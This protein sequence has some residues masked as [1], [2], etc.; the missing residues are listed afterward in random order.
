M[1][2][3]LNR[4]LLHTAAIAIPDQAIC[5]GT[6]TCP[7]LSASSTTLFR[8]QVNQSPRLTVEFSNRCFGASVFGHPILAVEARFE[9]GSVVDNKS[10]N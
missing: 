9:G 8:A 10:H 1:W 3:S 2:L 7:F 6:R 4:C 5:Q